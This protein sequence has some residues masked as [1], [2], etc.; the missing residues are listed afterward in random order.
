MRT[1][2]HRH[3]HPGRRRDLSVTVRATADCL[4]GG[5]AGGR[6]S[7]SGFRF[8]GTGLDN[9][10]ESY[11]PPDNDTVAAIRTSEVDRER[12]D[13]Q[14]L[15]RAQ[16]RR[17]LRSRARRTPGCRWCS[18]GRRRSPSVAAPAT[19]RRPPRPRPRPRGRWSPPRRSRASPRR[20]VQGRNGD[21]DRSRR[22][23]AG[24]TR[25]SPCPT[26]RAS[27]TTCRG[28]Q[29]GYKSEQRTSA[30]GGPVQQ[31]R[32]MA[33]PDKV[34]LVI[35]TQK[36]L[37]RQLFGRTGRG[38]VDHPGGGC[39]RRDP[40]AETCSWPPPRRRRR[41]SPSRSR[42][43][44]GLGEPG[45]VRRRARRQIDRDHRDHPADPVRHVQGG[46]QA[47]DPAASEHHVSEQQP[48]AADHD[49]RSRARSTG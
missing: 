26:P 29:P 19:V 38:R 37:S 13:R 35:E 18:T 42:A 44:G 1:G 46:R 7:G 33:Y 11:F 34:R 30:G 4:H 20:R 21:Q 27:F 39:G 2:D 16:A 6:R 28:S 22:R 41:P 3:R 14:H 9:L 10:K 17:G 5:E 48:A 32:H 24:L 15:H 43:G 47:R 40:A 25:P 49:P 12:P 23:A 36:A 45:R 31:V 8:P